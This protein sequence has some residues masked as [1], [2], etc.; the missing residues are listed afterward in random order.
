MCS[1]TIINYIGRIYYM[2][3]YYNLCIYLSS[4]AIYIVIV[5]LHDNMRIILI[6]FMEPI[7]P[8]K[9]SRDKILSEAVQ[10]GNV[11]KTCRDNGIS[12][13]T[14]YS[15]LN[16][17][18]LS[19]IKEGSDGAPEPQEDNTGNDMEDEI[20]SLACQNPEL[21]AASL[22]WTLMQQGRTTSASSVYR[23]LKRHDLHTREKRAISSDPLGFPLTLS[24]L[25]AT[26]PGFAVY[27]A[28]YGALYLALDMFSGY[29]WCALK[30]EFSSASDF[31]QRRVL[32]GYRDLGVA[33]L[34]IVALRGGAFAQDAF[35]AF[36]LEAGARY[37][38]RK[39]PL[40]HPAGVLF[41]SLDEYA[42]M[43]NDCAM[44]LD[45]QV[46]A[47]NNRRRNGPSPNERISFQESAAW[48]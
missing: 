17:Y 7:M 43:Q 23:V 40:E 15:W 32:S 27:A 39:H 45:I 5:I 14:F 12:R 1:L 37:W 21:G 9:P 3:K 35:K 38:Q 8:K 31:M 29:V 36:A 48:L 10:T 22:T 25:A 18:R 30:S 34:H 2:S 41:E 44:T 20:V 42:A 11:A 6:F 47:Y 24:E 4:F 26:F 46:F 28:E 33:P 16:E 13:V 19:M